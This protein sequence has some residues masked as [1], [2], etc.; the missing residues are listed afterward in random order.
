MRIIS[1][2]KTSKDKYKL[3]LDNNESITL[4]EDV[5]IN[6]NLLITKEVDNNLLDDLMKQNSDIHAYNIA[7]N[8]ISIR[9]RS[10]K[11]L[12]EYLIKK[13]MSSTLI[14]NVI[15]RL[16]KEGYL[17]DFKF[18]KAFVNDRLIISTFGPFK[19]KRELLNY[20]VDESIVNEVI[21]E[22]DDSIIEEKLSKLVEKQMRIKKGSANSI[23]IK[24]VNY[25]SNL[26]YDKS[27]ILKKL[28]NYDF[29]S[30]PDKLKKDYDK[31]YNKYKN[32]YEGSKL[33]YFIAQK[34][35]TKGYTSSDIT[36][37]I[38]NSSY[39]N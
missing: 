16:I 15:K 28:S 37:V 34:L 27:M 14:E 11:E 20:G 32:K 10:I 31:L 4:Y 26:G 18:A 19:I 6:N 23:K 13:N 17:N 8:Y 22:I 38:K 25:F 3:L 2:K 36:N 12:R 21:E 24:L 29:K 9:M 7:I 1:F 30:D 39:Q 5:I 35:Y 33:T